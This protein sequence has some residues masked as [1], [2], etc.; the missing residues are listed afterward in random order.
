VKIVQRHSEAQN[1]LRA[2]QLDFCAQHS[3]TLQ[4]MKLANHVTLHVNSNMST[5]TVFLDIEKAFNSSRHLGL[6]H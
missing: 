3:K 1:L 4:C 5:A 2:G 6:L